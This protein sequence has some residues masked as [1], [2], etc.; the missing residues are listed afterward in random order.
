METKNIKLLDKL[1]KQH[2]DAYLVL[3]DGNYPIFTALFDF[4]AIRT[5][6]QFY[7]SGKLKFNIIDN[8]PILLTIKDSNKYILR[9]I[10]EQLLTLQSPKF[11]DVNQQLDYILTLE[12]LTAGNS[13]EIQTMIKNIK[14]DD[15]LFIMLKDYG[16]NLSIYG[17]DITDEKLINLFLAK[18]GL[19]YTKYS[20]E[21][22]EKCK[23][24]K[25][26]ISR[27]NA[28]YKCYWQHDK[29]EITYKIKNK[30]SKDLAYYNIIFMGDVVSQDIAKNPKYVKNMKFDDVDSTWFTYDNKTMI[31][32]N[33][34]RHEHEH[35]I[36]IDDLVY[37]AIISMG[38]IFACNPRK[39]DFVPH[40]ND[41]I[42]DNLI[43]YTDNK[44]IIFKYFMK[45]K[46]YKC[47]YCAEETIHRHY[48]PGGPN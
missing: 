23:Y 47:Y 27:F 4:E 6:K 29:I 3:D 5:A 19:L 38:Y 22:K 2:I 40:K 14:F 17:F 30:L 8:L 31:I 24:G 39:N 12:Q 1:V 25:K 7:L 36:I 26:C 21:K 42:S 34:Y 41:R 46:P 11:T 18:H 9:L 16:V 35:K 33:V 28:D 32:Y 43:L 20:N 10:Y 37:D 13:E 45:F 44:E 15:V 48:H